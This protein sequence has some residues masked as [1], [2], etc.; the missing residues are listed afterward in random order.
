MSRLATLVFGAAGT[1]LACNVSRLGNLIEINNRL[2][3]LA[4]DLVLGPKQ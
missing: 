3:N 4:I 2:V 1:I